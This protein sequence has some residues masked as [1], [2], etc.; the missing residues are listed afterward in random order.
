MTCCVCI[1]TAGTGSRLGEATRYCNKSLVGVSN[2][3]ILSHIIDYF[4]PDTEFVIA[5]GHKGAL[6]REFLELAYPELHLKFAEVTPFEGPGSG[7]GLSLLACR[8][9]LERP[10][11]FMSCDTLV[12]EPVPAPDHTWMGYAKPVDLASFRTLEVVDGSVVRICEKGTRATKTNKPYIGLAGIFEHERFWREMEAGGTEAI[13]AGEAYGLRRILPRGI[14]AYEFSWID[15]GSSEGL[16]R[17]R[18]AYREEKAPNILEK[19]GE[20]IWFV[21]DSVIKYSNDRTFIANRVR[22]VRELAGFVPEVTGSRAHMYRYTRVEGEVLSDVITVPLFARLL[23]RSQSFWIR[24]A[25]S[26]E[27]ARAFRESCSRFYRDKTLERV[28][29]FYRRFSRKDGAQPINGIAMPALGELL[30]RLDWEWLTDGLPGRFHGDFHLENILW[31]ERAASFTFL[32]WRQEFGGDLATGDIYYDL[33]KLLHGLIVSHP[34]IAAE[35]FTVSWGDGSISFDLHRRQ[36][37]V[38]CEAALYRWLREEGFDGKK[39]RVLTALVFLNIAALH[40]YP[41]CLLLFALGKAMLAC[42]LRG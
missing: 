10:F 38:E 6:V 42:E 28:D 37:L 21:R 3:P 7:L 19:P 11:I 22:R 35:C 17:A 41:Y 13:L 31:D 25:L 39:V 26:G 23:E 18:E 12:R 32:D 36:V 9:F 34:L 27:A 16:A 2:R 29:F 40:H 30:A 14:R 33:A 15:T 24:A 4:P 5:L 8:E 1:P 20:A